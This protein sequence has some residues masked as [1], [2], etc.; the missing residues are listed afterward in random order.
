MPQVNSQVIGRQER[1]TVAVNTDGVD[2]ICMCV[3]KNTAW[4]RLHQQIHRPQDR[5]LHQQKLTSGNEKKQKRRQEKYHT[6]VEWWLSRGPSVCLPRL[7]DYSL[8]LACL[9]HSPS[10]ALRSYLAR[11]T[12]GVLFLMI[13]HCVLALYDIMLARVLAV[14]IGG[15]EEV[16][17]VMWRQ[18]ANLIDFLFN[19]QTFQVIKL[20]LM[21][22]KCTINIIFAL[23]ERGS[24]TR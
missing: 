12:K 7:W 13:H 1:L 14:T 18:P 19:L 6:P 9:S 23:K 3:S 24:G 10:T 22:L 5:D 8:L 4:G 17:G 21:T 2:V 11:I 16:G 20:R 15:E